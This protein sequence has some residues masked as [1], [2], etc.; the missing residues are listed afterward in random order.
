M[1]KDWGKASQDQRQNKSRERAGGGAEYQ[2]KP[3][4]GAVEE[5]K[6]KTEAGPGSGTWKKRYKSQLLQ[7]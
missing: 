1:E 7:E 2:E 6:P 5:E 3:G 4:A